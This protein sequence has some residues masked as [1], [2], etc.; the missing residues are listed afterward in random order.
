MYYN[1]RLIESFYSCACFF[2]YTFERKNGT[3]YEFMEG[4]P[5]EI[6]HV[7]NSKNLVISCFDTILFAAKTDDFQLYSSCFN[8]CMLEFAD[9]YSVNCLDLYI[10][11]EKRNFCTDEFCFSCRGHI[12]FYSLTKNYQILAKYGN[13]L[14]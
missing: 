7:F 14:L 12:A 10:N 11:D 2:Y 1:G 13:N 3:Y 8:D 9:P 4:L 6:F 5:S